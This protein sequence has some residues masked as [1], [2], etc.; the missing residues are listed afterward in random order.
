[1]LD[2]TAVV[3]PKHRVGSATWP[4]NGVLVMPVIVMSSKSQPEA[5]QHELVPIRN[6]SRI[7]CE[8]MLC[9]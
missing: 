5:V 4:G 3:A 8:L 6:R 2:A 7:A 9:N 1:M